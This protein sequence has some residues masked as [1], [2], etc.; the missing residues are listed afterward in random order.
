K[1]A[2]MVIVRLWGDGQL[3]LLNCGHVPPRLISDG[4]VVEPDNINPAIGLLPDVSFH[5]VRMQLKPGD[6][7]VL[8]TDGVVEAE[9]AA[10][11]FFGYERLDR[12][13]A[14]AGFEG[15]FRAVKQFCGPCPL[16]D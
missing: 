9:N 7:I 16:Q 14:E 10:G 1:Y 11:E 4:T 6:R 15:V 5:S 13:A 12:A 3:E 2:T 8:T